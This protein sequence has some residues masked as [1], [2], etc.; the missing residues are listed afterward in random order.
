MKYPSQSKQIFEYYTKNPQAQDA[1]KAGI[2]E[3]KVLDFILSKV[4]IKE[5]QVE[6]N[7]LLKTK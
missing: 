3:D 2:F 1:I 4:K 6:P 7:V 5:K